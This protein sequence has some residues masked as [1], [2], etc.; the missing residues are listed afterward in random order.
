MNPFENSTILFKIGVTGLIS[1]GK[2]T[3]INA[4]TGSKVAHVAPQRST[5]V[6]CH[7]IQSQEHKSTQIL[8]K[9]TSTNK[10]YTENH[11]SA[12]DVSEEDKHAVFY[13]DDEETPLSSFGCNFHLVDYP[14]MDD[15]RNE[16][17]YYS[18][19]TETVPSL[20]FLVL[21]LDS[22]A[23]GTTAE[24]K[25]MTEVLGNYKQQ[26]RNG[27]ELFLFVL[28][29]KLDGL[30][31]DSNKCKLDDTDDQEKY[32]FV[33]KQWKEAIRA[34]GLTE[35]EESLIVFFPISA[36][37]MCSN[38]QRLDIE[39]LTPSD[40]NR[41]GKEE[42]GKSFTRLR[43]EST[44]R[45]KVVDYLRQK[46]TSKSAGEH[47]FF[48]K[49]SE[50]LS[51][52]N[53]RLIFGNEIQ[54]NIIQIQS[55]IDLHKDGFPN[56]SSFTETLFRCFSLFKVARQLSTCY[57]GHP[58]TYYTP[59][60]TLITKFVTAVYGLIDKWIVD[61]TRGSNLVQSISSWEK[62]LQISKKM[63]LAELTGPLISKFDS[64]SKLNNP[65]PFK[66]FFSALSELRQ[67][68]LKVWAAVAT[69]S[70]LKYSKLDDLVAQVVL[71]LKSVPE[72]HQKAFSSQMIEGLKEMMSRGR[73]QSWS[74]EG[75]STIYSLSKSPLFLAEAVAGLVRGGSLSLLELY[76]LRLMLLQ[77]SDN[78]SLFVLMNVESRV[79][80]QSPPAS[81][82][83]PA[84]RVQEPFKKLLKIWELVFPEQTDQPDCIYV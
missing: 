42:F 65:Q 52:D 13:V 74:P 62:L 6:L 66:T 82:S 75:I 41:I 71:N 68:A 10:R 76:K 23:R 49:L 16:K 73:I 58:D 59:I 24:T 81:M 57:P 36:K 69:K 28:V 8:E 20:D 14:G 50:L 64:Y 56:M 33:E 44:K 31:S 48:T 27:L 43:K 53:R 78:A 15:E 40:I 84:M 45:Q 32:H 34:V 54:R 3:F 60:Y 12:M 38:S 79:R 72:L 77:R 9:V 80:S 35:E 29:N 11:L 63:T 17:K 7:F 4:L 67:I 25:I 5:M 39:N 18:W 55:S 30:V 2:S 61:Q 21:I 22:N 1:V 19:L 51:K 70:L 47:V 37:N 83:D 46:D 26:R